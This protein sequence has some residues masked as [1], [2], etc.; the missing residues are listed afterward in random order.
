MTRNN[1]TEEF[2]GKVGVMLDVE[3]LHLKIC[4]QNCTRIVNGCQFRHKLMFSVF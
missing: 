1:R 4:A 2:K 3:E